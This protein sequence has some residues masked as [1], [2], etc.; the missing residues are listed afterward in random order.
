MTKVQ[1]SIHEAV[2]DV[3]RQLR[4]LEATLATLRSAA[5]AFG[6]GVAPRTPKRRLSKAG[7]AAIAK[8]A[9]RRWAAFR[10]A[11]AAKAKRRA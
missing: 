5:K 2:V 10:A 6:T 1:A 4:T 9:R 3:E 11:K 8:A 7:S